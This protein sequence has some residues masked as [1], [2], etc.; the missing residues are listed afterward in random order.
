MNEY[1]ASAFV[2]AIGDTSFEY[3]IFESNQNVPIRIFNIPS[4][5]R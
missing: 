4:V 3:L 1:I 2:V 5:Y